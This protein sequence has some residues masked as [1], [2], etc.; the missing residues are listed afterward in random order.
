MGVELQLDPEPAQE[1]DCRD[2]LILSLMSLFE[3]CEGRCSEAFQRGQRRPSRRIPAADIQFKKQIPAMLKKSVTPLFASCLAIGL[4]VPL[5][6]LLGATNQIQ[7]GEMAGY[8]LVPNGKVQEAYNAG[9]SMYVAAWPLLAKYPGHRFQTGL[10]GTWM[11]A[12]YDGR[13]PTNMYSDIEGGLGWWTDTRF[14]TETPKFIMGGVAP[15]FSEW[16]NGPGAGQGRNWDD[17]KGQYGV[18]RHDKP[19]ERGGSEKAQN[20]LQELSGYIGIPP[21]KGWPPPETSLA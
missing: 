4:A 10:F 16:A 1:Q 12:Q 15:N 2:E 7:E 14:A 21:G 8:L 19:R 3:N 13:A 18:S 9:F 11:F 6:P 20:S 17:P 5:S